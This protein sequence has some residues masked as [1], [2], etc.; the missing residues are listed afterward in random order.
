MREFLDNVSL[1][2]KALTAVLDLW[3]K[4]AYDL[5]ASRDLRRTA[6]RLEHLE[7]SLP[8]ARSRFAIPFVLRGHGHFRRIAPQQI[9]AEIEALYEVVCELRPRRVLEIG[10]ARGGSLYLWLQAAAQDA[11]VVSVD[12]PSG[13]FGGGY[14]S[15]RI[16]LY[17][18]F[19]RSGQC[20]HL[21]REDSHSPE[22]LEQVTRCF[23]K[24]EVDFLFIDGDHTYEGV[25]ADFEQYAPLVRAGGVI[26]LHDI[27]PNAREPAVQVHRLWAQLRDLYQG[28]EFVSPDEAGGRIGIGLIRV[29]ET[30]IPLE[31]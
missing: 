17:Q 25:K 30:R 20:L 31:S 9:P 29:P 24:E 6:R 8:S 11:T 23:G 7:R 19:A 5:S 26:A 10:T 16:P 1:G 18:S 28:A 13:E 2:P 4:I 12:L 14:S 15:A 22:T 21:L 27:L 3:R